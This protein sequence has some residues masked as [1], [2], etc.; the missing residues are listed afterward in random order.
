M[1]LKLKDGDY[2]P[3]GVGGFV[4]CTGRQ[5][6]LAEALFRLVCRRGSFPPMPDL[7]STLYLLGREKPARRDT[8]ARQAAEEALAML[9]VVVED[10]RTVSTPEGLCTVQI[11]LRE[12]GGSTI[13]EV[14]L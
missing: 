9:P 3:D 8:A 7:G 13:L 1:E 10:A 2:V 5:A 14:T 6:L 4:R 12:N 11:F